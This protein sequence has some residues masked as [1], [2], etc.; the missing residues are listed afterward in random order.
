MLK[1]Y[2]LYASEHVLKTHLYIQ[3]YRNFY[4]YI[5]MHVSA[6]VYICKCAYIWI[7]NADNRSDRYVKT[8]YSTCSVF[9]AHSENVPLWKRLAWKLN[10]KRIFQPLDK[11]WM[12][13]PTSG[14]H[15]L[16]FKKFTHISSLFPETWKL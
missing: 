15:I 8:M 3:V 5:C 14:L 2:L 11:R 12:E 4:V 6:Y 10:S 9:S 13:N 7:N 16:S 1:P